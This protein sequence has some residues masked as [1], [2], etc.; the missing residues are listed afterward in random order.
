MEQ[1]GVDPRIKWYSVHHCIRL[2]I[3]VKWIRVRYPHSRF[4]IHWYGGFSGNPPYLSVAHQLPR[5][6]PQE[7][8]GSAKHLKIHSFLQF[9]ASVFAGHLGY[10]YITPYF[11][12][13]SY[14]QDFLGASQKMAG[15]ILIYSISASAVGRLSIGFLA[16][17]MGPIFAWSLCAARESHLSFMW[18]AISTMKGMIAWS[19]MWGFCSAGLVTLPSSTFPG[20]CLDPRK[21]GNRT[22]ISF[23]IAS[24]SALLGSLIAGVLIKRSPEVEGAT[25]PRRG[26]LGA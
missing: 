5:P 6:E 21:L 25:R 1:P 17:F 26:Y 14:A 23:E 3:G 18:M 11:F 19:A 7:R 8:Y 9:T 10:I 20:S 2:T 22:S 4:H 15:H 24:F 12:F 16:Y 13:P